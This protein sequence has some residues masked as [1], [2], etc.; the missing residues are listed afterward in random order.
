[1]SIPD[2]AGELWISF[3]SN[4]FSLNVVLQALETEGKIR[5][6][7]NPKVVTQ[8]NKK[9]MVLSG[10]KI[11]YQSNQ[12]NG[13]TTTSFVDANLELNVTPQITNE[14]TIIMDLKIEKSE[15][16]FSNAVLGTP[17]I[18]RR[19]VETQVLVRDGGTAVLG[20]VYTNSTSDT[21]TGI[22]FI[23]KLPVIGWLFRSKD[24]QE[25]NTELLI[26]VTPRIVKM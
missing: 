11:P 26:F 5:I 2:P 6:V 8:N 20:G 7:S 24:H 14:G 18:V 23:A 16:D 12:G 13:S 10:R 17:T 15:A 19:A 1:M 25:E 3:L 4:R 9:A 22:P 21:T